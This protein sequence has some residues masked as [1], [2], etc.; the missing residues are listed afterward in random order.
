[1][2][3]RSLQLRGAFGS[4]RSH[5][6]ACVTVAVMFL[7]AT[8]MTARLAF[9]AGPLDSSEAWT[10]GGVSAGIL[11][12][13]WRGG[14]ALAPEAPRWRQAPGFDLWA[15]RHLAPLPRAERVNF[16][17]RRGA[18]TVNVLGF[19]VLLAAS[20]LAWSPNDT[21]RD[22][23]QDQLLYWSGQA[24][25]M[26]VQRLVKNGCAR[27]RPLAHLRP[28]LAADRAD[29]VPPLHDQQSFWSGH[30]AS[31]FYASTFLN[32]RLRCAM[33]RQMTG[34]EYAEWRWA[35]PALLYGWAA[36]VG[37]SRIQGYEHWLSD[38]VVGAVAGWGFAAFFAELGENVG[39]ESRSL[40]DP[41]LKD[42]TAPLPQL[43]FLIRF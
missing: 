37:W 24:A 8:S 13:G 4:G 33:R 23:G 34:H 12:L 17:Q 30:A 21:W 41:A 3:I 19:G 25:L 1:M 29:K 2:S 22:V 15:E 32:L 11:L 40:T 43:A 20:D 6:G 28:D 39:N 5:V 31:A 42:A 27:E 38:V 9:A 10:V 26:G 14:E 7:L 36:Y 18:D 16:M 35:P